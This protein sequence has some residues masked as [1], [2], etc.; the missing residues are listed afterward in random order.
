MSPPVMLIQVKDASCSISFVVFL[1]FPSQRK[2]RHMQLLYKV[3]L[4]SISTL[5]ARTFW[6]WT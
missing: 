3:I 4:C 6:N 5:L 1:E 2:L